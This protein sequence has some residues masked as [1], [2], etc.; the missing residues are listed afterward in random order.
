MARKTAGSA[1]VTWDKQG[2]LNGNYVEKKTNVGTHQSNVYIINTEG[3][4][5]VQV[6]GS[7]VLDGKFEDVPLGSEV[8]IECLGET[9]SKKG[10]KYVDYSVEYDDE[11]V[12]AEQ[13]ASSEPETQFG[14]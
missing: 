9:T 2:E 4:T 7:T 3:D 5:M 10:T 6:W 12:L 1:G 13:A 8:W 14:K 11:A